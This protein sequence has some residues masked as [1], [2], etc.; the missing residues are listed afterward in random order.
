MNGSLELQITRREPFA[1]GHPFEDAGPCERVLGRA[2]F[3]VDPDARACSFRVPARFV[4]GASETIAVTE[5]GC[6][7]LTPGVDRQPAIKPA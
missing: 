2:H 7:I 6:E 1:D 4:I 3:A 5:T